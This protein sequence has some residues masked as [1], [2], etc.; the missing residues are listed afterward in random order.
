M[1]TGLKAQLPEPFSHYGSV[2]PHRASSFIEYVPICDCEKDSVTALAAYY[3][4]ESSA[5]TV[6]LES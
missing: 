2:L 1:I 4:N 3:I 6:V 5:G